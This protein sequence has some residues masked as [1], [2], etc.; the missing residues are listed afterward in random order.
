MIHFLSLFINNLFW[1][2]MSRK[3][4]MFWNKIF[5]QRF[6]IEI[7]NSK[8][9]DEESHHKHSAANKKHQNQ[10]TEYSIS[11][12]KKCKSIHQICV[13]YWP[14][15]ESDD[16]EEAIIFETD[17]RL[18]FN[19]MIRT[20]QEIANDRT[21]SPKVLRRLCLGD[22]NWTNTGEAVNDMISHV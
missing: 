3:E 10:G 19:A 2:G 14:D 12:T 15:L 9:I 6:P 18:V 22:S 11:K 21:T 7:Q 16:S 13:G 4:I 17:L 1:I 8:S 5:E 20:N